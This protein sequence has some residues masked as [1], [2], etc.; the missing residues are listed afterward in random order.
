MPSSILTRILSESGYSGLLSFLSE[1]L[2][3]SDFQS[4][5]LEV[6]NRRSDRL[7]A[8][9]I[10]RAYEQNRFVRPSRVPAE[11]LLEL[12]RLAARLRG[13]FEFIELSPLA[14]LGASSVLAT[15]HQNKVVSA[16]RHAE[17]VSDPTNLMALE[18]AARRKPLKDRP[19][20]LVQPVHL[21]S[22]QRATRAQYFDNPDF[23]AHF[24]IIC[25]CTG[26][27]DTG[28]FQFEMETLREHLVFY[29]NFL[30]ESRKTGYRP[31]PLNVSFSDFTGGEM[32]AVIGREIIPPL[33]RRFDEVS[34]TFKESPESGKGY[35]Q[36]FRFN[37]ELQGPEGAVIPVID[38]GDVDWTRQLLSD[39]KERMVISAIGSQLYCQIS[40]KGEKLNS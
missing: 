31:G 24:R 33:K 34:F 12:D 1:E 15:V 22:S 40:G 30:G 20:E 19:K 14:P 4:L 5:M 3:G 9:D 7:S 35:Y 6:F 10:L 29:L 16:L 39:R 38:G 27:R 13:K 18:I 11:Q 28:S 21:M 26:G 8:A 36:T 23:S 37:I 32:A 17:A 2:S 25:L